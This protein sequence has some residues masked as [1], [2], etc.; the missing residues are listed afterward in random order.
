M[1]EQEDRFLNALPVT[2]VLYFHGDELRPESF[3]GS[4]VLEFGEKID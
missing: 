1:M 4:I 3:D 2:E